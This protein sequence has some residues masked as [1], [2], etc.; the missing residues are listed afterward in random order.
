MFESGCFLGYCGVVLGF[1]ATTAMIG[2]GI[3]ALLLAIYAVVRSG[4]R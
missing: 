2:M 3:A 4:R 1:N